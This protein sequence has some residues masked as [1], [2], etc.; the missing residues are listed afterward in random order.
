MYNVALNKWGYTMYIQYDIV[1]GHEYARLRHSV[2]SGESVGHGKSQTLGRVL[3]KQRLIFKSSI[4]G[5]YQYDPKIGERNPPPADFCVKV[6]RKN[7]KEKLIVDFG[8]V[9]FL[10][11]YIDKCGLRPVLDAIDYG[12]PNSFYSL[13]NF[14]MLESGSNAH[15]A[16]WFEGSFVRILYPK[17]SLDSPRISYMLGSIGQEAVCR[18]FFANYIAF[19]KK[20]T[21]E[22]T[23]GAILI[24]STGLPNDIRLPVT[25]IS[26]HNGEINNEV[27]LIYVVQRGTGLPIYM[28]YIPGN[29]VDVSTL[30]TAISELKAMKVDT[31]FAILDAGYL[32]IEAI[33]TLLEGHVSFLA[34][35]KKNWSMYKTVVATH[36]PT[37]ETK[38]HMH[39]Y[40]GRL[41]YLKR[42]PFKLESGKTVY[43]YLGL[44]DERRSNERRKLAKEAEEEELSTD[45]IQER[46]DK[47]GVFMLASSRRIATKDLLP[48]YYT[49]QDI[50]QVFDITKGYAKALPLNVQTIETFR[51]H[52][53][54]V[55]ISTIILRMLQ[56]D[57][58]GTSYSLDDVIY[59]MRNQ[60][61][62]VFDDCVIP[63]EPTKKQ[64]DLYRLIGVKPEI[65]IR[66]ALAQ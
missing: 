22:A 47:M 17:A 54:M 7:A 53:L 11:H 26:N 41:V 60:K 65:T 64:N 58:K 10:E 43:Y 19:L 9:N 15:A 40:N 6:T 50:E 62:K 45:A 27:R 36:L 34:R 4:Y 55:F 37:L 3:D 56:Q 57:L 28:R 51:G 24:D 20:T 63:S 66:R 52:L 2:R 38:E 48:L 32:T 25:A 18:K 35:V 59:I 5:V 44:D 1:N 31:K 46:L 13:L 42:V 14:Y 29:V 21:V 12:N 49:R 16:D 23:K 8:N 33:E 39:I 30:L 61:A